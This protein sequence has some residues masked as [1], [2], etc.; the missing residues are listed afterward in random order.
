MKKLY[1]KKI[2]YTPSSTNLTFV[3]IFGLVT[4]SQIP[5]TNRSLPCKN[6]INIATGGGTV[7]G[8]FKLFTLHWI[9]LFSNTFFRLL[10]LIILIVL[11]FSACLITTSITPLLSYDYCYVDYI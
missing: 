3:V 11:I 6:E 4:E 8:P 2:I 5:G 1:R 9:A 10:L 7:H